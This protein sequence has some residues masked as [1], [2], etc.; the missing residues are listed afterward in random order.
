MLN[1]LIL[2]AGQVRMDWMQ[3]GYL[4]VDINRTFARAWR[5]QRH[6]DPAVLLPVSMRRGRLREPGKIGSV[7]DDLW[8]SHRVQDGILEEIQVGRLLSTVQ[9]VL[10]SEKQSRRDPCHQFKLQF[11]GIDVTVFFTGIPD[12]RVL[13]FEELWRSYRLPRHERQQLHRNQFGKLFCWPSVAW[14]T[15]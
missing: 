12:C 2:F 7:S 14:R 15:L 10:Q 13:N 9:L 4:V 6:P 8:R 1:T 3:Q 11:S 5:Y